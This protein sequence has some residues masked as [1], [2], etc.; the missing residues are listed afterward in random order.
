[1]STR[2]GF[3]FPLWACEVTLRLD[4]RRGEQG[5]GSREEIERTRARYG[6]RGSARQN[7]RPDKERASSSLAQLTTQVKGAKPNF[8]LAPLGD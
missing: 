8:D 1:M 2:W 4:A 3:G 5:R 6:L 7:A